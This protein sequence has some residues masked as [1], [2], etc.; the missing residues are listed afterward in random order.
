MLHFKLKIFYFKMKLGGQEKM[1]RMLDEYIQSQIVT[2]T[3][4]EPVWNG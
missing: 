3:E 4:H 2:R 1:K